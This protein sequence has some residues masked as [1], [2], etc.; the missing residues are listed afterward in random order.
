MSDERELQGGKTDGEDHRVV[1][2]TATPMQAWSAWAEPEKIAGWFA[3]RAEGEAVPG[4]R[5]VHV[6]SSFG[7]E[8]EHEV[9]EAEP[10][11]LLVLR[12]H[13]PM[14]FDFRQEVR[15]ERDGGETVIHLVHSG[16]GDDADWDAEY[17][18]VDSGWKLA[19]ALLQHYL[20]NHYG[21]PRSTFLALRPTGL[22][23]E[24]VQPWFRRGDELGRWLA[25]EGSLEGASPGEPVRLDLLDGGTLSGRVLADSGR[26]IAL[27]WDEIEGALELKIFPAG[28]EGRMVALRGSSWRLDDDEMGGVAAGMERALDRLLAAAEG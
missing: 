22:T 9:L 4:G 14:G 26:E 13:S 27:S 10:G 19:L 28:P 25:G 12:G 1:R 6:F 17:E 7:M 2:T 24:A 3:D 20:E 8:I 5:I 15:I 21:R 11:K 23:Y 16:F 18:G